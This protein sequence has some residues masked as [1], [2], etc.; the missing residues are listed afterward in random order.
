MTPWPILNHYEN[1]TLSEVAFPLGGIGTGT[2]SLGGRGEIRDV[3][4]C[5]HPEKGFAL[6]WTFFVLRTQDAAGQVATRVL[7]G[8]FQP[9]YGASHGVRGATGSQPHNPMLRSGGAGLPRMR[10]VSLDAA[11]PFARY[12]FADPSVPLEAHLEAFNPLIP[13]D[14]DRSSLPVAVLRYVLRNPTDQPI[15]AALAGCFYNF[16]GRE[17]LPHGVAAYLGG[18]INTPRRG[19]AE[20]GTPL[21]GLLMSSE[22]VPTKSNENGTIALLALDAEATVLRNW[23]ACRWGMS[24]NRFWEDFTADGRLMDEP[25]AEP[26]LRGEGA[27]GSVAVQRTV[28]PGGAVAITFML[29]W[30][31]PHRSVASC[32][33]Q[34]ARFEADADDSG[35]LGNYYALGYQDAWDV[36]LKVAPQLPGLE[37]DSL[38]FPQAMVDSSLPQSVKEACL[39]NITTLRTEACFRTADG[40]FFGFEGCWDEAGCCPGTCTHVWNYEQTMPFL[41]PELARSMRDVELDYGTLESGLNCFRVALPLGGPQWPHAAADGQ[42]GVVMKCFREWQLSGDTDW[43]CRKWPTIRSLITFCWLPG[44]W[45]ADQDGVMEGVQHNTSDIEFVGPNPL[46]GVWYLGALRASQEMAHA[47]GDGEHEIK[48]ARLF[49]Q[50]SAW[51]D[52]NLYNG[53]YYRQEIRTLDSLGAVIPELLLGR[54][55]APDEI[56]PFQMGNGCL[57]D[58]LVG[59][60]MAHVVGLGYLLEPEHVAE[61]MRSIHRFNYLPD[62]HDY[63]NN[64]RAFALAD[65][66]AL[67]VASWPHDDA[68]ENPYMRYCEVWTGIE[69]Q[70]AAGMI[71]EGLVDEGLEVVD[72]IRARFDGH[73]RN[74]WNELECGHHYARAMASWSVLLALSGFCYSAVDARLTVKPAVDDLDTLWSTPQGWGILHHAS[75]SE[76]LSFELTPRSG[77]MHLREIALEA[78]GLDAASHVEARLGGEPLN[79]AET[80][81]SGSHW[82]IVLENEALCTSSASLCVQIS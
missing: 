11:Y 33:W 7:E 69:Y 1:E 51:F 36:A 5:G 17:I 9:P 6:P 53:E 22:R 35:Y 50:G 19:A 20:D 61:T 63:Y 32:G 60:Y 14:V 18:N 74:P 26:S 70:A 78:D 56:P 12:S 66:A 58:Q 13:L 71:Y 21:T 16:L 46:S 23:G 42:M 8:E 44:G 2:I 47:V 65:E 37:Q 43:L 55:G 81:K 54:G 29:T 39:N 34:M 80:T 68:P 25:D 40:H 82:I 30:H 4:L 10:S 77:A 27:T 59:Q 76:G 48:C 62:M 75:G 15:E 72:A 49:A 79:I 45:D 41:F 52:A 64:L 31:M 73:R 57:T 67:V 3:E 38:P 28:P 24:L